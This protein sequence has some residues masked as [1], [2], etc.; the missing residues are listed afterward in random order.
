MVK[1]N[2]NFENYE[3]KQNKSDLVYCVNSKKKKRDLFL[4]SIIAYNRKFVN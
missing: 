3:K 1:L 2:S 4:V